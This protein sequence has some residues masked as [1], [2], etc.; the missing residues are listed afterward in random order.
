MKLASCVELA[1]PA[2]WGQ[3]EASTSGFVFGVFYAL[4]LCRYCIRVI[5]EIRRVLGLGECLEFIFGGVEGL[6]W[7]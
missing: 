7:L 5:S 2:V 3:V 4:P 6:W 1:R